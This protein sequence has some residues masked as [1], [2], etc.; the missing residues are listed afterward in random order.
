MN[1][2]PLVRLALT[3]TILAGASTIRADEPA[4]T[5]PKDIEISA[6][7]AKVTAQSDEIQ[8]LRAELKDLKAQREL[9]LLYTPVPQ[10]VPAPGA[11]NQSGPGQVPPNWVRR[12]INGM[13]FYLVPLGD[14][15]D[16]P[17]RTVV[18][19]TTRPDTTNKR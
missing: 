12:E 19:P 2:K 18:L 10:A 13:T 17:S 14:D 15:K 16:A 4:R 1:R 9:K 6:L 11:V 7:R 3:L 5:D 8:K